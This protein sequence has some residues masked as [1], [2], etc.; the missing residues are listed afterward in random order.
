MTTIAVA[1]EKRVNI[2]TRIRLEKLPLVAIV[3]LVFMLITAIFSDVITPHSPYEPNLPNR[4]RPP[5]WQPGGSQEHFLGTDT[6]GRDLLTRIFYGARVSLTV[7]VAVMAFGGMLG[8]TLGVIAG[9]TGGITGGVIMR[10]ADSFMAIPSM[11]LAL[12]FAI[13]LGPSM[14]TII[15]ALSV[16]IWARIARVVYGE[17]LSVTTRDFILQAKVA[18]C[19]TRRIMALHIFPNVFNTFMVVISLQLGE[20]VLSEASLSFLEAGIP[21]PTPSWGQMVSEGRGYI[22]SAWWIAFFPGLALALCVFALNRFG[23][24]LRDR[25]DPRL[26]QL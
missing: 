22:T 26:R 19:S 6:L 12:V 1:K 24:W 8:L 11:L 25:L 23:D 7:A 21:P 13:T 3:I 18:G 10:T 9:Y 15:L 5:S 2:I 14:Q 20:V 17:V 4:L 16:N